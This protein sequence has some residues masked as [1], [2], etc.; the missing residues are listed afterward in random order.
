MIYCIVREIYYIKKG[1]LIIY[2]YKNHYFR[3][4]YCFSTCF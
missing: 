4:N 2:K 3:N 1:K